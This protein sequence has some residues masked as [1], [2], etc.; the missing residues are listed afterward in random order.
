[1]DF[2]TCGKNRNYIS[3]DTPSEVSALTPQGDTP[4]SVS[5]LARR[6]RGAEMEQQAYTLGVSAGFRSADTLGVST[7]LV[8]VTC[9][10][11]SSAFSAWK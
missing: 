9:L 4:G 6:L 5:F 10:D 2:K 11:A 3:V 8:N 1:M 7:S